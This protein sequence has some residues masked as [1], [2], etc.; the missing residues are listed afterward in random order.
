MAIPPCEF[1]VRCCQATSIPTAANAT[2]RPNHAAAASQSNPSLAGTSSVRTTTRCGGT[3][4]VWLYL[5]AAATGASAAAATSTR[6]ACRNTRLYAGDVCGQGERLVEG[7][8]RL[9]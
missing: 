3:F 1:L 7:L 9:G 6:V 4:G 2:A 5:P 8:D